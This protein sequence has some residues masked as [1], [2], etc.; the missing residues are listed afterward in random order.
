MSSFRSGL[1]T[2]RSFLLVPAAALLAGALVAGC[3]D[4]P[5][6]AARARPSRSIAATSVTAGPTE[7]VVG[8]T[9]RFGRPDMNGFSQMSPNALQH[10]Q[11]GHAVDRVFPGT[12]VIRAGE[13]VAFE[14]FPVHQIA[15]YAPGTAPGDIRTDAEHLADAVTPWGVFP[16]VLIDDPTNR[17]AVSP[18]SFEPMT[19]SPAPGTFAKP[20]RYLV[21]CT[22]V[23]HYVETRMYGWVEVR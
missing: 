10:T 9:M 19:W 13:T 23:W 6:D 4:S 20:G 7:A 17:L 5:T 15:V 11:G 3:T 22:L 21:L 1:R 8:A 12:V 2:R 16:D 14:S 18:I